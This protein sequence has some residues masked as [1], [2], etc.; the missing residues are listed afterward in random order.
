MELGASQEEVAK[1]LSLAPS[2]LKRYLAR[3]YKGEAPYKDL[4][5][6]FV[7]AAQVPD[8]N[9][10]AALYRR[11]CGYEYDEVTV[12]EKLTREGEVVKLTKV[13]RKTLPPDPTSM[14][15]WLA[16]RRP[17]KWSYRPQEKSADQDSETGVVLL[18]EIGGE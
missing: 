9:V 12:E 8:D 6:L 15:F 16:N 7:E 4:A 2:T 13:T 1:K 11:S 14:M 17:E 5:D 3:G 10:E 18:P